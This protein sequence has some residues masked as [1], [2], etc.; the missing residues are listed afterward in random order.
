MTK[1][2][3]AGKLVLEQLDIPGKTGPV[4]ESPKIW[5]INIAAALD[6]FPRQGLLCC[7]GPWAPMNEGDFVK[8]KWGNSGEVLQ[9]TI[10]PDDL[11]QPKTLFVES[12]HI[13]DGQEDVFYSVKRLGQTW[14]DSE[15]IQLLI[16]LTRPGGHDDNADP[17]HSKL[18]FGI[19]QEILDGGIDKDNVAAGV[20]LTVE[21]YPD[22]AV[23]DVIQVTWGGVFVLSDPLTQ[24]QVDGNTPIVVHISEAVIREA[25][26]SD[27][28][29]LDVAFEVYDIADNRSE[30]W[31][32]PQR[33]VVAVDATR[34]LA[35]MLKDA[36]NNVLDLDTLGD[37]TGKAQ[38]WAIAPD[39]QVGDTIILNVKGT[40]LEGSPINIEISGKPLQ[41]VPSTDEIEIPNAL[42]R[43]L[44]K[45]QLVLSYLLKKANGS[46]DLRSKAQFIRVIGEIQRLAAPIA[47]DAVQGA[48]DPA[49]TTVRV[50][51]PWDDS[52]AAGQA[53][54]LIWLGSTAQLTPYLPTLPLRPITNGDSV[55]KEPLKI[56]V[57]GKHLTAINGGKL[58]LYYEHLIDD[59]VLGNMNYVNATHAVRESL[60]ADILQV[61]EPRLE[62]PEPHVAAVVDGALPADTNG[63]TLTVNYLDTLKDDEVF[64]EWNGSK[65]DDGDSVTLT[66]LTA[67][68]PVSFD[69]K[70]E[71]IKGNEGGTVSARYSIKR[72]EGGTSYSNALEFSVGAEQVTPV[73]TSVKDSKDVDI[74]QNGLTVDP[75]VKL[76][77][78]ATPNLDILIFNNGVSTG[79]RATADAQ[80]NWNRNLTGLALGEC[81]LTA[82]AQYGSGYVSAAWKV[83]VTPEV[84]PTITSIKDGKGE[85]IPHGGSTLETSLT[86]KGTASNGQKVQVLDGSDIKGEAVADRTTAIW[87]LDIS[88][89]SAGAHS[90]T[91][92]SLYGT[93][94]SSDT[95][96]LT[97]H[98]AVSGHEDWE[99]APLG[100]IAFDT[101]MKLPSGL[102]LTVT[103]IN[104]MA[105]TP[106]IHTPNEAPGLGRTMATGSWTI[107]RFEF[108][109]LAKKI[110]IIY[111]LSNAPDNYI[112]FSDGNSNIHIEYL[113]P[114]TFLEPR[115]ISLDIGKYCSHFNLLIFNVGVRG[116]SVTDITWSQ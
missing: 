14:E 76:S 75:N 84:T 109:G 45:A 113:A 42:L 1:R 61:G 112:A 68:Q 46:P 10:G 72:A 83:I 12:R 43:L 100:N 57:E 73:I 17:G 25:G 79:G 66:S 115:T 91:A 28:I 44:A 22:M 92:K 89:L 37:K 2:P 103:K 96:T 50:E 104:H 99:L 81:N 108:G 47:L 106:A 94:Q 90:F 52:F 29:G 8:I 110:K 9:K 70:A 55:A 49:L 97:I 32:V 20:P 31:S 21:T 102:I 26:D 116:T 80:G 7:A 101:P 93:G 27:G 65:V 64:Y 23:G 6:N 56:S 114:G 62:L 85:E 58:E 24:D 39:F 34:I 13:H 5:G 19:P 98:K 16:K 3:I 15:K 88:A 69:I 11:G 41:N 63:T 51:I 77:G 35:P 4:S 105:S 18:I 111:R 82:V 54:K 67:G 107:C 38:I 59:G 40:P 33:V 87:E 95:R 78:T 74:P 71:Y 86:L 53:I 30:D 60:H 48:L 36:V